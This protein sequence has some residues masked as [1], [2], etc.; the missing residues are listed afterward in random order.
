MFTEVY[1]RT[2]E[3][4]EQQAHVLCQFTYKVSPSPLCTAAAEH[5]VVCGSS[6]EQGLL[7]ALLGPF[8][9]KL[10]NNQ[11]VNT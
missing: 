9:D 8:P 6:V 2:T 3:V 11:Y 10:R 5:P 7:Q 1:Y 4:T